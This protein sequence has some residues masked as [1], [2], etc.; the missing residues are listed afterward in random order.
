[1]DLS[2]SAVPV[3]IRRKVMSF[4]VVIFWL[5]AACILYVYVGYPLLLALVG[6]Y[7]KDRR[8]LAP[9]T[10]N[11][12]IVL[13]ARNEEANLERRLA[14]LVALLHAHALLGEILV[15]SD[16]SSDRTATIG[17]NM[18]LTDWCA[19]GITARRGQ[20][21]SALTAGCQ[22][23]VA[24]VLVF[25]DAR[26]RWA[27]DALARLLE[28]FADPRIGA[29]SGD[30][31]LATTSG[32]LAGVGA[33]WRFEKW[34]RQKESQIQSQVGVTGAISAVRRDLFRPIPQGT[35]LDDVYW[36]LQVAM[37]GYRVVHDAVARFRSITRKHSG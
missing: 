11:V 4:L 10:G 15:V 31:Q 9:F 23:C 37:Q 34:L 36:P 19:P 5:C 1:M 8:P 21:G 22:T 18:P 24:D 14:E 28:N 13:A 30:L 17:A 35:L 26:Q 27:P 3:L 6:L 33:Y 7:K 12:A 29:V 20:G 16:G 32:V 25:A 2:F